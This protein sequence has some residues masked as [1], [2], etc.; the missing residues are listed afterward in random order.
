MTHAQV[1]VAA[2][3]LAA[4]AL[5]VERQQLCDALDTLRLRALAERRGDLAARLLLMHDLL[6][7]ASIKELRCGMRQ[8]RR[9][10]DRADRILR[11]VN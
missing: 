11:P 4:Q 10:L 1:Q 7:G 5:Q 8:W 3:W 2:S 6:Q 9:E